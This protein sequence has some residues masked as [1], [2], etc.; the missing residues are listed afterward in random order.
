MELIV[1]STGGCAATGLVLR[2]LFASRETVATVT[3]FCMSAAVD[4]ALGSKRI[5]AYRTARFMVHRA[6]NH[7]VG[8]SNALRAEAEK[9]DR[10]N[11]RA[12]RLL[13]DRT[14]QPESVVREWLSRDTYF[15]AEEA[16]AAGLAD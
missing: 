15:T 12:A 5:A 2:D 16:L 8:D 6:M 3:G 11:E 9:L 14:R 4:A 7:V 13:I 10:L 1:N